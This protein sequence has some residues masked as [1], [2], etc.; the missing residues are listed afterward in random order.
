MHGN[1]HTPVPTPASRPHPRMPPAFV[2]AQKDW[3]VSLQWSLKEVDS[4]HYM[5]HVV[6]R[7]QRSRQ[8]P[9]RGLHS[10]TLELNLSNSRTN[11]EVSWVIWWNE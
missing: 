11:H 4:A 5:T 1:G 6:R 8:V 7:R 10:L 9:T 3:C 2:C